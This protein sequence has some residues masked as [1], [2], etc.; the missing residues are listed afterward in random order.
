MLLFRYSIRSPAY[1][2][3]HGVHSGRL[4]SSLSL[5]VEFSIQDEA[6]DVGPSVPQE[7]HDNADFGHDTPGKASTNSVSDNH[8]L[9]QVG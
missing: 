3:G 4:S 9:Y 7:A 5:S 8:S 6:M 2:Q 1:W